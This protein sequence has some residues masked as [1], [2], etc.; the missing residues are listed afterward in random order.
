[1]PFYPKIKLNIYHYLMI[2]F[3]PFIFLLY[4]LRGK[5]VDLK[6]KALFIFCVFFGIYFM[7]DSPDIDSY[8]HL[9]LFR[10]YSI[11]GYELITNH[12]RDAIN[13][14][15]DPEIYVPLVNFILSRFTTSSSI[16][17]W[18]PCA[19]I[20]I[21]LCFKYPFDISQGTAF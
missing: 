1:M 17:F 11:N 5:S 4:S 21:F 18:F 7:P 10:S 6:F 12:F 20:F 19:C 9:E 15:A 8:R 13:R 14:K 2:L 3:S 16:F